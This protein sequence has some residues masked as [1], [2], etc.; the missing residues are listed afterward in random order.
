M[1]LHRIR[2]MRAGALHTTDMGHIPIRPLHKLDKAS[3][4]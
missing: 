1:P 3:P 4:L 2:Q